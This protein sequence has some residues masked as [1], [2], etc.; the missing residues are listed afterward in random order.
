MTDSKAISLAPQQAGD[1][2]TAWVSAIAQ[3]VGVNTDKVQLVSG[4][5]PP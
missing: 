3:A 2:A 4:L 5:N 1:Q